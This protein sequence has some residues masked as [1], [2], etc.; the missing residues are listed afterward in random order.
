MHVCRGRGSVHGFRLKI[1]PGIS[2]NLSRDQPTLG[3]QV[4]HSADDRPSLVTQST[5]L[6]N[7][8]SNNTNSMYSCRH[9]TNFIQ[10]VIRGG[11]TGRGGAIIK[12]KF[13]Q[14]ISVGML[15]EYVMTAKMAEAS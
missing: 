15:L 2:V 8:T 7:H 9:M 6:C 12:I 4:C 5:A 13:A 10:F 14:E 1:N 3:W 11:S